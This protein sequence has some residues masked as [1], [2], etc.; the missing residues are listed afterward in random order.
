M[1]K[2]KQ[3]RARQEREPI[4]IGTRFGR[5][6]TTSESTPTS[7]EYWYRHYQCLCDCGNVTS[8][9]KDSLTRGDTISCGCYAK[10]VA[11][12]KLRTHGLSGNPVASSFYS[13]R[14]RCTNESNSDY[15]HYGGRGIS[16]CSDWLDPDEGLANFI[17]DMGPTHKEGL[18]IE[19]IDNDG[20]YEPSNCKWAT[21][22][23]QVLNRRFD[24]VTIGVPNYLEF[25]GKTLHLAAWA[26]E[27][28]I[29]SMIISD[30]IGKLGWSIERA[31]TEPVKVR[32]VVLDVNSVQ[33]EV[34][35]IFKHP[36]NFA[37]LYKKLGVS[38]FEFLDSVFG[39]VG[40]VS[41]Y[42]NK[43]WYNHKNTNDF[44]MGDYKIPLLT[45]NFTDTLTKLGVQH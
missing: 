35:D 31:L 19:R 29:N 27:L 13:M 4:A 18:E 44:K 39:H 10:E 1:G 42:L 32:K 37:A 14:N 7:E 12:A 41:Y 28:G 15:H 22:R 43:T 40:T 45:K 30:R 23:E 16:V 34:K 33:F 21:R 20:N 2:H 17:R 5:L 26:D 11:G 24:T 9:R 38:S 3:W 6:V 8:P 36:P 25:E